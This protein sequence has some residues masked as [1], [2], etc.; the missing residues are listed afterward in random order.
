MSDVDHLPARPT[1]ECK[2][3]ITDWPCDQARRA[4]VDEHVADKVA[5]AMLMWTY[6]EDFAMDAGPGPLSGAWD[7]FLGW[8]RS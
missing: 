3:C 5:L 7:R 8:T 2:S 6:L 4:L 1:W